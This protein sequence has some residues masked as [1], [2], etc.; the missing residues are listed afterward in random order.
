MSP[1]RPTVLTAQGSNLHSVPALHDFAGQNWYLT[2]PPKLQ[3][4]GK[5]MGF[6]A[7]SGRTIGLL[8]GRIS[9]KLNT[10]YAFGYPQ[11][12]QL[13]PTNACNIHCSQCPK[14][15]FETDNRHLDPRVYER[16]RE[17]LFP[18]IELLHLQGLGEP[19]IAPL[20]SHIVEDAALFGL[21]IQFV[22]NASVMKEAM[23]HKL[24]EI[25]AH[26]TISMDGG[27]AET[28]EKL[29]HGSRFEKV[30]QS[31]EWLR[32][33]ACRYPGS[34]FQLNINTVVTTMN[35]HELDLMMD[36]CKRYGVRSWWLMNPGVGDRTDEFARAA[37][38]NHPEA[39]AP[40]LPALLSHAAEAGVCLIYP[41]FIDKKCDSAPDAPEQPTAVPAVKGGRLFPGRCSD[42]WRR[43]FID[44]DG[45]VRPCCRAIW[46]GMGNI[47]EEDFRDIWNNEHFL[48][49][50][51]TVHTNCPPSFCRNCPASYGITN[52]DEQHVKRL[53]QRG[54]RLAS[55]PRIGM[56]GLLD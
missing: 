31:F 30:I 20:F 56:A 18:H 7:F 42:P 5:S 55:P 2:I 4:I 40:L 44:V 35:V 21:K 10:S 17:Q 53:E 6:D 19:M 28:H 54:V 45:W 37:I 25:G 36:I 12:L 41:G 32:Q 22:T 39:L 29:R 15:W 34:G 27:T 50:R 8:A 14:T 48:R 3:H 51:S 33:G 13:V 16:V 43:V 9:R 49:L 23:A 52:G 47:L 46:V 11:E 24:A 1:L 26:V 38:G